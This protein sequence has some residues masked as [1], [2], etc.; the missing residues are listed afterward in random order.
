MAAKLKPT[1]RRQNLG[2]LRN[3]PLLQ[4]KPDFADQKT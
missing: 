4:A 2:A 3:E 1:R